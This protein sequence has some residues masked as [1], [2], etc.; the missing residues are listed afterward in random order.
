MLTNVLPFEILGIIST[1][2]STDDILACTAVCKAWNAPF[3]DTLWETVNIK[4]SERLEAIC[5]L[6]EEK[7]IYQENGNRVQ[8]LSFRK[9]IMMNDSQ[10]HTIQ[11]YFQRLKNLHLPIGSLTR[12]D[13]GQ[14]ADWNLWK[15]LISLE[16]FMPALTMDNQKE[17]ILNILSSLP[18]L[19]RLDLTQEY[20]HR[21]QSYS[22]ET[23]ESIHEY[24]PLLEH[25]RLNLILHP[26][27][28]KDIVLIKDVVP[29]TTITCA[30][31]FG[32]NMDHEWLFYFAMK[33]PNLQTLNA[34]TLYKN[35][36][37]EYTQDDEPVDTVS[38]VLDQFS[39]V[40]RVLLYQE[41]VQG[42]HYDAFWRLFHEL[43][44]SAKSLE[45]N[46]QL[47]DVD[48]DHQKST[49]RD[50]ICLCSETLEKLILRVKSRLNVPIRPSINLGIC[51]R[52]V[53]LTMEVS[54]AAVEFDVLLD[55]CVL[56]NKI[57]FRG[58]QIILS[59]DPSKPIVQHGLQSIEIYMSRVDADV[60]KYTSC[61]CR[62]L[63]ELSLNTVRVPVSIAPEGFFYIDMSYTHFDVLNL[64]GVK[65]DLLD[66]YEDDYEEDEDD[67]YELLQ[68]EEYNI[69][70][71]AIERIHSTSKHTDDTQDVAV[72]DTV[73]PTAVKRL[74]FHQYWEST[75]DNEQTKARTLEREEIRFVEK[76]F[77]AF[78]QNSRPDLCTY[79]SRFPGGL[80]K[81]PFWKEDL[82]RGHLLL[83]CGYV[84]SYLI[85]QSSF[86]HD[87]T[88]PWYGIFSL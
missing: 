36:L 27:P 35:K 9:M 79:Q 14:T 76:Y 84:G 56:L 60:F 33:Y 71:I 26:I 75:I 20:S 40:K 8:T 48:D 5:S 29:A 62:N 70:L 22:W 77:K 39:C 85:N 15:S 68:Y 65:F 24:L 38:Q 23:L 19:K 80:V 13:F 69:N 58:Q 7:N 17:E 57:R 88:L 43:I 55:N 83:R 72:L 31:F 44:R 53:D 6:S 11:T 10:L 78:G 74:W 46:L 66:D 12:D 47:K 37:E 32:H 54:N 67:E 18:C 73:G 82:G 49:V 81:K 2:I 87:M 21:V 4:T 34:K 3:K 61:R 41:A 64:E 16:I 63:C 86:S 28:T 52:L 25:L 42:L 50:S 1:F 30:E 59:S 45:Y 51:P